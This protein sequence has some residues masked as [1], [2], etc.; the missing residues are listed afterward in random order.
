MGRAAS[1]TARAVSGAVRASAEPVTQTIHSLTPAES[2]QPSRAFR[3]RRRGR[4]L[5]AAPRRHC[6]THAAEAALR[7]PALQPRERACTQ[8][9]P[10]RHPGGTH[11]TVAR[12]AA[13]RLQP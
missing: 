9:A 12:P 6:A 5:G 11:L 7:G 4:R 3:G 13:T 10:R 1:C 2:A 8:A